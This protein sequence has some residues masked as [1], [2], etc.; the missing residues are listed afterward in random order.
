M[1]DQNTLHVD[2]EPTTTEEIRTDADKLTE[3][4]AIVDFLRKE[5]TARCG[6][7]DS[8]WYYM[9]YDHVTDY[10]N[11]ERGVE[12]SGSAQDLT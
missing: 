11:V 6:M 3:E 7:D 9:A 12:D 4:K 5:L 2:E 8:H 10:K 1:P